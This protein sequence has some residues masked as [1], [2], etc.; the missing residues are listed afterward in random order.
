MV[1]RTW[2]I[3]GVN[4]GFG[5]QMSE[6]LL[7]SGDRVAGTARKTDAVNDLRGK[8]GYSLLDR[9]PRRDPT[10]PRGAWKCVCGFQ[11]NG[12]MQAPW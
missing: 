8:Y 1:Q 5:C 3:T 4:S 6:Q 12:I 10:R 2:F 7:A 11:F 9:A